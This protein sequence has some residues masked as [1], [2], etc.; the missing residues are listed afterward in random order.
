MIRTMYCDAGMPNLGAGVIMAD[1]GSV[2]PLSA[3]KKKEKK[4]LHLLASI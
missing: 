4:R 1:Q 2:M 3:G